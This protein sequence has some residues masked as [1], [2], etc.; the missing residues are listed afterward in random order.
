VV[1][2]NKEETWRGR[3]G[4]I[5]SMKKQGHHD[6]SSK[7]APIILS[8]EGEWVDFQ[9][10]VEKSRGSEGKVDQNRKEPN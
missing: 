10:N 1:K 8:T 5:E 2:P 3:G 7:A 4:L 9:E 6:M